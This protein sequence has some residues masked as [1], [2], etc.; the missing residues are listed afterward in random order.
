M[1]QQVTAVLGIGVTGL[2]V[3]RF[4]ARRGQPFVMVDTRAHPPLLN[5]VQEEYPEVACY[6]GADASA[7]L[8]TASEIVAS[9]GLDPWHPVLAAAMTQGI[10]VVGDIEL[11][12]RAANAPVVAITGS[13]GKS[14]VTQLLGEMS[15][16]AARRVAVGGNIG[17]PA[18]EV[19]DDAC[20]LYV[21]ELS[22]FQLQQTYSLAPVVATILNLSED[23]LDRYGTLAE[24]RAAKQRIFF[25]AERAVVNRQDTLTWPERPVGKLTRFGLDHP[26][27]QGFGVIEQ[28]GQ[29][30]LADSQG[31]LI[32][33]DDLML[34]GRHNWANALAALALGREIGLPMDA[35]LQTLRSF[36]GL[37][38]RCRT[39]RELSG[40]TYINDSKAT[41]VGAALAALT[42]LGNDQPHLIWLAGGQG[43]GADF[44]LLRPAVEQHVKV[45]LLFGEDAIAIADAIDDTVAIEMVTNLDAAVVRAR[46]LAQHGDI[47]LLSPACASFDMFRNFED[48]GDAFVA[49]V[50]GL[51]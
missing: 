36:T 30:W 24:Y 25:G 11:F 14:T 38:H 31:A 8:A 48:R 12:A 10:P 16:V 45:A 39:V 28:Q 2:S 17:I 4:L 34:K 7:A 21:L 44:S 47:V 22:S 42:G 6:L 18:L 41:N 3:A 1:E 37:P 13:N 26:D 23:H 5:A 51:Q 27:E 35:M 9:P 29:T 43:K 32:A 15:R 50:G 33:T 49:A 46:Q 19:L 40:V 20:E